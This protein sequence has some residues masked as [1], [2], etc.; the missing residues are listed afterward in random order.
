MS[1]KD[2]IVYWN[3][4]VDKA[5]EEKYLEAIDIWTSMQEPGARILFNV[6]SMHFML[7]NLDNAER[8]RRLI[9]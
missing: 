6:A 1:L 7:G 4:G 9:S 2:T 5:Q 3:Q 8:V